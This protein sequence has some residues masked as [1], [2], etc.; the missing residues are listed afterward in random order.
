MDY[1]EHLQPSKTRKQLSRK[2]RSTQFFSDI[3]P[4]HSRD[5]TYNS[6]RKTLCKS[7]LSCLQ[8]NFRRSE[9]NLVGQHFQSMH[10]QY[11][12]LCAGFSMSSCQVFKRWRSSKAS[13]DL[14]IKWIAQSSLSLVNSSIV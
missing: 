1:S 10:R 2:N 8:I 13:E 14:A 11:Y 12:S 4:F 5:S 9:A 7:L 3:I 6:C